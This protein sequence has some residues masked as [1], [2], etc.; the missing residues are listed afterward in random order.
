MK[1]P[2]SLSEP[3][4]E[5]ATRAIGD[6]WSLLLVAAL[7]EG[8]RRFGELQ[9]AI[10]GLAPNILTARLRHLERQGVLVGRPY[11]RRPLRVDYHLTGRGAELAGA[12]R[13]LTAWDSAH[14]THGDHQG[15]AGGAGGHAGPP[16]H[17]SCGTVME[18]RWWCPT[19]AQT[20]PDPEGEDTWL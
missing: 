20:A 9:N 7:M 1:E 14:G 5:R 12:I 11:S 18:P 6:R 17:A 3:G 10:P 16:R 13:L 8:P 15:G 19:C 2:A 4:L